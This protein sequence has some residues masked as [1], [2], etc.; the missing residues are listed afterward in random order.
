[1]E[2]QQVASFMVSSR[3]L[4]ANLPQYSLRTFGSSGDITCLL[5]FVL[6][7]GPLSPLLILLFNHPWALLHPREWHTA[8]FSYSVLLSPHKHTLQKHKFQML[9]IQNH[10]YQ[11]HGPHNI[12]IYIYRKNWLTKQGLTHSKKI[13]LHLKKKLSNSLGSMIQCSLNA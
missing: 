10:L 1:M 4:G 8:Q 5:L 2:C 9:V 7:L 6:I 12:Y 3:R 11:G 13:S